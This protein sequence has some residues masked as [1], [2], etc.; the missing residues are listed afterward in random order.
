MEAKFKFNHQPGQM[1]WRP[2]SHFTA[3]P[4]HWVLTGHKRQGTTKGSFCKNTHP[5][6]VGSNLRTSCAPRGPTSWH[7]HLRG[8]GYQRW[9]LGVLKHSDLSTSDTRNEWSPY[10][11]W[12]AEVPVS[13]HI[14]RTK[15]Q[16][17]QL[18]SHCKMPWAGNWAFFFFFFFEQGIGGWTT[19]WS[20]WIVIDAC[21]HGT[22]YFPVS[23]CLVSRCN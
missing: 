2:S 20:S 10:A 17:M 15:K 12:V 21:T 6:H 11:G 13:L 14:P 16:T 3:K 8:L 22:P 9:D 18:P 23:V 7:Q 4:P 19:T 5:I 1:W